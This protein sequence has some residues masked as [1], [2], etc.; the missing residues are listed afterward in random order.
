MNNIAG[1]KGLSEW[2]WTWYEM[3]DIELKDDSLF[4]FSERYSQVNGK[5]YKGF[6]EEWNAEQTMD[7]RMAARS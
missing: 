3:I 7:R 1:R 2:Q 6:N 5:S 4:F